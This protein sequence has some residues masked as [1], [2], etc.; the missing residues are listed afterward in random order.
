MTL[1]QTMDQRNPE[2]ESGEG[3][4]PVK[5]RPQ[6]EEPKVKELGLGEA[7]AFT[8]KAATYHFSDDYHLCGE[9]DSHR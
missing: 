4:L 8:I 5:G 7:L 6:V 1:N 9:R 2:K 3:S